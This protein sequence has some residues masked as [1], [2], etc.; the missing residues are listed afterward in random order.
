MSLT[1]RDSLPVTTESVPKGRMVGRIYKVQLQRSMERLVK[2]DSIRKAVG[3]T[4]TKSR[5]LYRVWNTNP[6]Y[7]LNGFIFLSG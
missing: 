4:Q 1:D 2:R 7:P 6:T 3:G 5:Y